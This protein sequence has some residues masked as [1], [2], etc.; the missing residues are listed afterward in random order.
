M[1]KRD[2]L[3]LDPNRVVAPFDCLAVEHALD[4][5]I[6]HKIHAELLIIAG[7]VSV[8]TTAG[9]RD[10]DCLSVLSDD[11]SSPLTVIPTQ[12]IARACMGSAG[13]GSG[14]AEQHQHRS[15]SIPDRTH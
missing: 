10:I 11:D 1:L 14:S 5:A 12:I 15:T 4:H 7:S 13:E 3:L 9:D 2:K 8:R 6:V